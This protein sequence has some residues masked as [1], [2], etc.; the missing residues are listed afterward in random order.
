MFVTA[1]TSGKLSINAGRN[2]AQEEDILSYTSLPI[3]VLVNKRYIS[4]FWGQWLSYEK[5]S[6]TTLITLIQASN[7]N[8]KPERL[9]MENK[10]FS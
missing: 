1:S 10:R 4:S 6:N 2:P 9:M 3:S 8:V 5:S 7:P